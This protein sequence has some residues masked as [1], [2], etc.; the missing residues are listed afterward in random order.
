MSLTY[1]SRSIYLVQ[2]KSGIIIGFG[3]FSKTK[4]IVNQVSLVHYDSYRVDLETPQQT[5]KCC[6]I[7]SAVCCK[8]KSFVLKVFQSYRNLNLEI[9]LK[10]SSP[11][12][13]GIIYFFNDFLHNK[14]FQLFSHLQLMS[15]VSL[16]AAHSLKLLHVRT[17]EPLEILFALTLRQFPMLETGIATEA[18]QFPSSTYST[19]M[20]RFSFSPLDSPMVSLSF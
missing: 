14:V 2:I 12:S 6:I 4:R 11:G 16:I 8:L 18:K 7:I 5:I 20:R 1:C 19:R 3:N 13:T 15:K 17:I 10:Y 9:L